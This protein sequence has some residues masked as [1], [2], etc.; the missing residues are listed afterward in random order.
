MWMWK[1][2]EKYYGE[3]Y[4]QISEINTKALWRE[5]QMVV[6]LLISRR[7]V[8]DGSLPLPPTKQTFTKTIREGCKKKGK[9]LVPCHTEE[10][11]LNDKSI[12]SITLNV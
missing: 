12:V 1:E 10:R 11:S 2:I 7:M 5:I 6:D 3:K 8:G 9:S 4:K